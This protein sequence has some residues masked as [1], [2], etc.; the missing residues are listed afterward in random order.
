MEK[1]QNS[2]FG[3]KIK[4]EKFWATIVMLVLIAAGLLITFYLEKNPPDATEG[5]EGAA[6][7]TLRINEYSVSNQN[8]FRDGDWNSPD[9]V[10]IYNYGNSPIWLGDVYF[11][12]DMEDPGKF[13][14]PDETLQPG[15]YLLILASGE[16][17]ADDGYIRAPFKLGKDDKNILLFSSEQVLDSRELAHMPTDISAGYAADGTFG[18]FARPTPGGENISQVY[19]SYD[20]TPENPYENIL[21]INEYLA[22]NTYGLT[23]A[24]GAASDWIELYNPTENT[25]FLGDIY[26][27]DDDTRPD[28]YLLPDIELGAG[29]YLLIYASGSE[30]GTAGE[31]HT[32]FKLGSGDKKLTLAHK[33]GYII[34]QCEIIELPADVSAGLGADGTFGFF[35]TPTPGRANTSPLSNSMEIAADYT[36]VSQ[37]VI[38]EWMPNNQFGILDADGDASDWLE[39]FNPA[40]EAVALSGYALT[41]DAENLFKWEFPEGAV[42]EPEGY[43]IVFLSG[44]ERPEGSELHASFSLSGGETVYLVESNAAVADSAA[45]ESLPGNVSKGRTAAGYGYFSLPT[46]GAANTSAE[47]PD[48]DT[49]AEFVTGDVYISE[50]GASGTHFYRNKSKALYEFIEFYNRGAET[51][52]LSGYSIT[53]GSEE[54]FVFQDVK[55]EPDHYLLLA[56]KGYTS[57]SKNTIISDSLSLNSAGERL[58]LYNGSGTVIDCYDTGYLLGDYSSGRVDGDESRRVFF[59]EKTPG[60]K[61]SLETY[62][63]YT[64]QPVFSHEGGPADESFYLTLEAADDAVIYYTMNGNEPTSESRQYTEP[65]YI[66]K[67]SIVRAVA[68]SEGRLPSIMVSK[69]YILERQHTLPIVCLSS[70]P[71]GLFYE[72]W[73]IYADGPGYGIGQ[74][75]YFQSNYF[76]DIERAASF[77][78]YL[79]D[80]RAAVAFNAGIQIA[81]GYTRAVPQK[82]LVVRLR[83]EYGLSEVSYPFFDEGASE[84]SHLYLRAA[85]QDGWKTKIRDLFIQ[86]SVGLL[87]T[88]DTKRGHPAVVYINGEYWGLYNLRDKLN[89]EYLAIKYGLDE[90]DITLISE[91]SEAKK[92]S[93]EEWLELKDFCLT[94]NFKRQENYD[95]L[96]E[97]VDVD[98]FT[99]YIIAQTFFGNVDT[100]NITFWKSNEEGAKWKPLLFD[101]DLSVRG[102]DYS[103]VNMYLGRTDLG[104]DA[105][106]I[107][108]LA[109]NAGWQQQFLERYAY[110]LNNIFTE[111]YL[112]NG[113]TA[114]ADEMR[115]EMEYHVDR[116][117]RPS[118][119]EY[120]EECVE[121]FRA[122]AVQR[123]YESVAELQE[124]FELD[125]ETVLA[126]FPW[127]EEK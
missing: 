94:N 39:I 24:E 95:I 19:A 126:L 42:I 65:I 33:S 80:G 114:L 91:Y 61:N 102:V 120:W 47:V 125:D 18:Y 73:G 108:C 98:A 25:V 69:T 96:A 6:P 28:K 26:I 44:K 54:S 22:S 87:G 32:P 8:A 27:S 9:W 66:E 77:E 20:I 71:S 90:D 79:E 81:G 31:I 17:E 35:G 110:I 36:P 3:E 92:G 29:E 107:K 60:R 111:E 93:D 59:T 97:K 48:I 118:S 1:K 10:E 113:I 84:F 45:V 103:M 56:L 49:K 67:D 21:I 70:P 109:K 106:I 72:L 41:D 122:G 34:N 123:R 105:H 115:A 50:V 2:K 38:N 43:L 62:S 124:Y 51:I 37:L 86:N 58:L 127:Y 14:L 83:D 68:V 7:K 4:S 104:F 116:W 117:N 85:G 75:P 82:P 53:D 15:S 89:D 12:D 16:T 64:K 100:H 119:V 40:Q 57:Q 55:L 23:D 121:V 5:A 63:A 76:M 101:M 46:P 13:L 112:V 30:S 52:D 11:S 78:Y 74:Y 88:V 99:D